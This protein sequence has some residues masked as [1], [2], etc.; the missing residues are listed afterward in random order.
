PDAGRP[1]R[2][3]VFAPRHSARSPMPQP[4]GPVPP[5]P[6]AG[7]PEPAAVLPGAAAAQVPPL[8]IELAWG[9]DR[10]LVPVPPAGATIGSTAEAQVVVPATF[11]APRH[12][13]VVP[14]EGSWTVECLSPTGQV[15]LGGRSV[16]SVPIS[17]GD[18]FRLAD[19]IGNFV[20]V[21]VAQGTA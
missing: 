3:E 13:Q 10:R 2:A 14:R 7:L 1:R 11:L 21:K 18:V 17:Q 12:A 9:R 16:R 6:A 19:G 20:T 5:G 15:L 8:Q 4:T